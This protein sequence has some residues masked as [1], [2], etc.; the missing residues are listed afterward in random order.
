MMNIDFYIL[1]PDTTRSP[2]LLACQ[3]AEKAYQRQ[4][5]TCLLARDRAQAEQLDQLLWTFREDSFLPHAI[6]TEQTSAPIT[7]ATA[8]QAPSSDI[9]INLSER[10][11]EELTNTRRVIEIVAN[12]E[13]AK[14]QARQ[15]YRHY[16][17]QGNTVNTHNIG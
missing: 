13:T 4:Q 17:Q 16:Q 6:A 5:P 11:P 1:K 7:I 12:D 15:R 9:V 8:D 10:I 14:A 2:E 3:L